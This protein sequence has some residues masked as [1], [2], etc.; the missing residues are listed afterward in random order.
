MSRKQ[1]AGIA[2]TTASI[3]LLATLMLVT[4]PIWFLVLMVRPSLITPL[5]DWVM[6]EMTRRTVH[7]MMRGSGKSRMMA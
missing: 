7:V 4:M 6:Q 5:A 2:V 1:I 3:Y